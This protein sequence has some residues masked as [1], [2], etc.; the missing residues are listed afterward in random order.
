MSVV[1]ISIV[2]AGFALV[3]NAQT[4]AGV[5][6]LL[7]LGDNAVTKW[8]GSLEADGAHVDALEPWRFEGNDAIAVGG[9]RVLEPLEGLHDPHGRAAGPVQFARRRLLERDGQVVQVNRASTRVGMDHHAS[10]HRGGEPQVVRRGHAI[11]DHAQL[12]APPKCVDDLAIVRDRRL[13]RQAGESPCVVE[14][15]VDPPELARG[16]EALQNLVDGGPTAEVEK[17]DGGPHLGQGPVSD[18]IDDRLFEI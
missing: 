16:D 11:D 1:G 13:L 7:G 5:R 14:A 15:S 10:W 3:A 8:D 6:L 17:I 18:A 12:V 4:S 9:Q 2:L